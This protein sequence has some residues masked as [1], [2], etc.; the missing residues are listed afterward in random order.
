MAGGASPEGRGAFWTSQAEEMA[1]QAR[2][3]VGSCLGS[4]F[5]RLDGLDA[6]DTFPGK[7]AIWKEYR[8]IPGSHVQSVQCV[9]TDCDTGRMKSSDAFGVC[10][11]AMDT[12]SPRGFSLR[13][14][15][16]AAKPASEVRRVPDSICLG[17]IA[18][19]DGAVLQFPAVLARDT[20]AEAGHRDDVARPLMVLA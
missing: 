6:L 9:R 13:L 17:V 8:K 5:T 12:V 3:S 1:I 7:F 10:Q 16:C 2:E 14:A 19:R 15:L 20:V 11:A 18:V 4:V